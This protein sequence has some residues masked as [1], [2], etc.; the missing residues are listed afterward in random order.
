M[1][2]PPTTAALTKNERLPCGRRSK[3]F[4]G[5][6]L[7]RNALSQHCLGDLEEACDVGA[8]LDVAG[9]AELLGG[10]GAVGVDGLHDALQLGV[11]LVKALPG[12][13]SRPAD[14]MTSMASGVQGMLE[15]SKTPMTPLATRALADASSISF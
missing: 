12:L 8:G 11:H 15:P 6:K 4:I 14:L 7:V 5:V 2:R 3:Q 1:N 13:Y 10:G 9:L